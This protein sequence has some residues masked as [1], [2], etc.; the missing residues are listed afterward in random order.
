MNAF[1]FQSF[2]VRAYKA[3][4][5][6]SNKLKGTGDARTEQGWAFSITLVDRGIYDFVPKQPKPEDKPPE[7][8]NAL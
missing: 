8:V 1:T 5:D 4:I 6:K 7:G 3:N 2:E